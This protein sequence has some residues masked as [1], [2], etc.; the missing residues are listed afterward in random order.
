MAGFLSEMSSGGLMKYQALL[1]I[2]KPGSI[3]E[4]LRLANDMGQYE[5]S[6]DYADPAVYGLQHAQYRYNLDEDCPLMEHMNLA[7]YGAEMLLED[8]YTQTRYG[9]VYT[10]DMEFDEVMAE[11]QAGGLGGM[12]G[13]R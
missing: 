11:E 3:C 13:R 9:A 6:P 4:A 8:G 5:V 12:G 2:I 1:E 10:E 7:S